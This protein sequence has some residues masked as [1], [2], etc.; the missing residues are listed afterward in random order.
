[1]D[2][3][4][5]EEYRRELRTRVHVRVETPTADHVEESAGP[6]GLKTWDELTEKFRRVASTVL[7]AREARGILASV[8]Q[9]E[10]V[11]DIRQFTRLLR[12]PTEA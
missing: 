8:A 7:P 12:T 4:L 2:P 3:E 1:M 11:E 9:L 6:V 10:D 5:D